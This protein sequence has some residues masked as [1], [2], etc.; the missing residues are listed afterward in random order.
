MVTF[1]EH[2]RRALDSLPAEL[3]AKLENV[4]V[5]VEEQNAAEPDLYGLFEEQEFLPARI[6]IYRR[7]LDA[8]FGDDPAALEQEIRITVLH[9][10]AHYFGLD[11]ERLDELG[12][13]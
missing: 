10:V 7:P 4:A 11:E 13:G 8:D 9:E 1:E 3:A 2:V 12:Y 6:A 5:V